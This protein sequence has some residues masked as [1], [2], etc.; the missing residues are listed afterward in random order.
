MLFIKYVG[1]MALYVIIVE[2]VELQQM[3]K[4][5]MVACFIIIIIFTIILSG[6]RLSP[7]GTAATTGLG[8]I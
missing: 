4:E 1:Y 5:V 8:L 7:L 3:K 2:K 6:V